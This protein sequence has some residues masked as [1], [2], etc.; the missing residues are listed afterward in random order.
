MPCEVLFA[1]SFRSCAR[2]VF[3]VYPKSETATVDFI[4]GLAAAPIQGSQ[5]G[6]YTGYNLRKARLKLKAYQMGKSKGLRLIFLLV[7]DKQRVLPVAL[8]KKG[9]PQSETAV[10]ALINSQLAKVLA[11]TKAGLLSKEW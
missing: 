8:W 1:P 4:G 11:D 6:G 2:S 9:Q 7:P 5:L 3:K 10:I